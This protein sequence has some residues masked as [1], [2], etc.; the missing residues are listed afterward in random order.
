MCARIV[1]Q[2]QRNGAM[3]ICLVACIFLFSIFGFTAEHLLE[4]LDYSAQNGEI[5]V[6]VNTNSNA[7]AECVPWCPCVCGGSVAVR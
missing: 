1:F 3:C 2:Q 5:L 6:N 7:I 4:H